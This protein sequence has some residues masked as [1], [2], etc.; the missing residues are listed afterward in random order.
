MN[1]YIQASA[2]QSYVPIYI[3]QSGEYATATTHTH[4]AIDSTM[5]PLSLMHEMETIL[6]QLRMFEQLGLQLIYTQHTAGI[7]NATDADF[8]F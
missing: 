1:N 2:S 5:L 8:F 6:Q 4:T 7:Q 3:F